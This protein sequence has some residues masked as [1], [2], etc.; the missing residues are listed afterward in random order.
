MDSNAKM[1]SHETHEFTA[2]GAKHI[3][4]PRV[5]LVTWCALLVLMAS[6]IWAAQQDFG[7]ANNFIAM[8]IAVTKAMLVV[9]FFMQ[10]KG[11]TRLTLIWAGLGFLWLPFLFSTIA[12]YLTRGW[13]PVPG[14][15]K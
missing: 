15:Q 5:Y 3:A 11:S 6:T 12:D 1:E 4:H 13:M 8:G 9:A 10:V 14:W 2:S 7:V